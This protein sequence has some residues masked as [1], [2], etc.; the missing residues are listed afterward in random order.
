M[1]RGCR[2]A[3]QIQN[4]AAADNRDIR[5]PI[6]TGFVDRRLNFQHQFGPIFDVLAAFEQQNFA[7]QVR[8]RYARQNK[9]RCDF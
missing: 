3:D 7:R 2:V 9:I 8:V 6:Q 5:V 1:R 4:R